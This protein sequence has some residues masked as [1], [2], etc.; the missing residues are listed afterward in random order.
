VNSYSLIEN[1]RVNSHAANGIRIAGGF[2]T[3]RDNDLSGSTNGFDLLFT[4]STSGNVAVNNVFCDVE[5]S[6]TSVGGAG[7]I[8]RAEPC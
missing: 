6:G 8:D 2:N 5:P 1:N 3:I 7:N 4:N